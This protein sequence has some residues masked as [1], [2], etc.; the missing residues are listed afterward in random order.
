[1][2]Q[3]ARKAL[4]EVARR[5]RVVAEPLKKATFQLHVS[6]LHGIR[7]AVEAGV[8]P[9]ANA[10]VEQAVEDKLREL[11][12]SRVYAAYALAARDPEFLADMDRTTQAF[13]ATV[14][15]GLPVG[16][17]IASQD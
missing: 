1:M 2:A 16:Q 13:E 7:G 5:R 15:D 14:G 4:I 10:L 17:P 11:R 6:V 8:A 3:A 9:S 12:R